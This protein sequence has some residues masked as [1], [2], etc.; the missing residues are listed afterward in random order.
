VRPTALGARDSVVTAAI[1]VTAALP[2]VAH[3]LTRGRGRGGASTSAKRRARL[4]CFSRW[5][6]TGEE[7]QRRG[8]QRSGS[9]A[10]PW[11]RA[12]MDNDGLVRARSCAPGAPRDL[13]ASAVASHR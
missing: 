2:T 5:G 3:P 11:R 1:A 9:A 7:G 12:A 13:V 10:F 4:T 6:L 8:G